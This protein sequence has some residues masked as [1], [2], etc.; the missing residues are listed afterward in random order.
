MISRVPDPALTQAAQIATAIHQLRQ[1]AE[2][3]SAVDATAAWSPEAQ[4]AGL[5]QLTEETLRVLAAY[6]VWLDTYHP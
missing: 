6:A 5:I 3:L 1:R 2:T 4:V